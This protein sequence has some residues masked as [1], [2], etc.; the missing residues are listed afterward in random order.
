MAKGLEERWLDRGPGWANLLATW[1]WVQ[2]DWWTHHR[3]AGDFGWE[4]EP[5]ALLSSR[6]EMPKIG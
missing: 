4:T 1:R 2:R 3:D 6:V 5:R